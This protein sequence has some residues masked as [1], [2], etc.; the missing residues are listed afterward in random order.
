[1]RRAPKDRQREADWENTSGSDNTDTEGSGERDNTKVPWKGT[2]PTPKAPQ[3]PISEGN[4]SL[5]SMAVP[6]NFTH[7]ELLRF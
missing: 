3:E 7:N 6:L 4:T 2:T 5:F 1:M